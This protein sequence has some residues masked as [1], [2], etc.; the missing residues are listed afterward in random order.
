[1]M[2]TLAPY[3]AKCHP[4]K[5]TRLFVPLFLVLLLL[6]PIALIV[7]PILF[8]MSALSDVDLLPGIRAAFFLL[9]G[10]RGTKVDVEARNS[11]FSFHVV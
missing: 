7:L 10:L 11:H 2:Q 9:W 5:G 4:R 1:M 3:P 6:L 8:V